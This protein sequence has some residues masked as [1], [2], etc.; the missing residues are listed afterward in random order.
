VARD[1][2]CSAR[3]LIIGDPDCA[4]A[5]T[6]ELQGI[7]VTLAEAPR[8]ARSE[9]VEQLGDTK[10]LIDRRFHYDAIVAAR[11]RLNDLAR[12]LEQTQPQALRFEIC[13]IHRDLEAGALAR[14]VLPAGELG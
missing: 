9:W 10:V 7:R 13:D 14:T 11:Q 4:D 6:R 3:V 2:R 5:V 12:L 8:E 1:A